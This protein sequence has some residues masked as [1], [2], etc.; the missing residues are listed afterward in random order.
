MRTFSSVGL[1]WMA[2]GTRLSISGLVLVEKP[3]R[4]VSVERL[5]V[6]K[7]GNWAKIWARARCWSDVVWNTVPALTTRLCSCVVL[8]LTAPNT[9]PVLRTS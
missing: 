3:C 8:L 7:A 4:A 1:S 6:R 5:W 2:T 9:T